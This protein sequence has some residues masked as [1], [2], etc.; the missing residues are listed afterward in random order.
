MIKT[1]FS[2]LNYIILIVFLFITSN[3]QAGPWPQ[4]KG[5]GY[6][7]LFEWWLIADQHFTDTGDIDPNTTNGIFNTNFY[8]E[9][10]I[11]DRLTFSAYGTLFSRAFF[12]NTVSGTTGEILVPGEAINSLG[13][14]ELNIT[15]GLL[16]KQGIALSITGKLGI[17]LG[18]D[19]GGTQNNLQT[20]DGEFNQALFLEAGTSFQ[21]GNNSGW[22]AT[23]AGFNNRTKGFSDEYYINA[24]IGI[25]LFNNKL[26][27]SL[28]IQSRQSLMNGDKNLALNFTSVFSNNVEYIS[29]TPEIAYNINENYGVSAT[30]G[31]VSSGSIIF[32]APSYSFGFFTKF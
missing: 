26:T 12:N 11:T 16:Q 20:G 17:P 27:P 32:A 24:Q 23:G 28:F 1:N 2:I 7:K 18:E 30:I 3:I 4:K 29:F 22:I 10:G 9:L 6:L 21:L 25:N 13:D 5:K 15:Y 19:Q 14:A 8:G 31:V